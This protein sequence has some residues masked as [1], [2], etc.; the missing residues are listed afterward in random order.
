[1]EKMGFVVKEVVIFPAFSVYV[2]LFFLSLIQESVSCS[3]IDEVHYGLKSFHSGTHT[4]MTGVLWQGGYHS[5]ANKASRRVITPLPQN[6]IFSDTE[7]F[8]I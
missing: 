4:Y 7:L 5:S 3:I 6:A 8:F 1:M 2:S